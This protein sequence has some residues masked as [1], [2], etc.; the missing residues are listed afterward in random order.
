[1]S[2]LPFLRYYPALT[3]QQQGQYEALK[4]LY[5]EWNAKINVISRKDIDSLY[6]RHVQHSLAIASYVNAQHLWSDAPLHIVDVGCGGG[7]PG[8][9]LAIFFPQ[10]QFL[11]I[12]RTG[13][14]ITVATAVAEAIGLHN[15]RCVQGDAG[16]LEE[17]YDYAVSRAVMP[18]PD[19][20]R[21]IRPHVRRGLL[22]LKGGDLTDELHPKL[23]QGTQV[24]PLTAFFEEEF[25]TTKS[26]LYTPF[27]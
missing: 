12:D 16:A 1:M 22:T 20:I 11:L 23:C 9:P 14:K 13:K 15:V 5:E 4:A 7:F 17:K 19:L 24:T 18:L 8:I 3:I 2:T 27:K 6:E 21:L 10:H 26:V 25:F